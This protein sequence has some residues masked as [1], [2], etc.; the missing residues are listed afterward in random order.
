MKPRR[1]FELVVV[2]PLLTVAIFLL[3]QTAWNAL[4]PAPV[5]VRMLVAVACAAPLAFCMG[6]PF[7]LG[8]RRAAGQAPDFI[9]WA[10]GVNGFA[11]VIS[12]ALA[13]LLAIRFGF[14]FV[15]LAALLLY[16]FAAW[17]F[18]LEQHS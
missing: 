2:Y 18:R 7:P 8:L 9:P 14:T 4:A 13:A 12:A 11:S 17:L 1:L 3:A 16:A 15:L 6:M 10:W 5:A